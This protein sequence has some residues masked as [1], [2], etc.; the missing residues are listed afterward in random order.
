MNL[1]SIL[2]YSAPTHIDTVNAALTSLPGLEV[3]YQCRD[4]GKMVV[5]QEH[6]DGV[7]EKDGLNNIKTLPHV[8][9]AEMVYHYLESD[10]EEEGVQL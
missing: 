8:L 9:A 5:I 1:S 6:Q 4:T 7:S 3:H 2:V 10:L